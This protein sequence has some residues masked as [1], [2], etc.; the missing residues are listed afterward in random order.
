MHN[1]HAIRKLFLIG[2]VALAIA[3][4]AGI[5]GLSGITSLAQ[6]L[7]A[8][9]ANAIPS[10]DQDASPYVVLIQQAAPLDNLVPVEGRAAFEGGG[11]S[12]SANPAAPQPNRPSG[13]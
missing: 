3:A 4:T 13:R 5:G 8:V 1:R 9:S 10:I 2:A 7:S 12:N 11:A 6:A